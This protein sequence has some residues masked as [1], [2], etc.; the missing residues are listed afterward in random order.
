M[1]ISL[2]FTGGTIGS[3][4]S[5][6]GYI[7]ATPETT[8]QI[9]DKY[10][11]SNDIDVTFDCSE[12]YYILSENLHA[13]NLVMLANSIRQILN[14]GKNVD[15]IIITH[16]TD[17]LQYTAA[18]LSYL[19]GDISVPIVLVSSAYVLSD[20]RSNG[21]DNFAGAISF[22]SEH[23]GNGVFVSYKNTDN[24]LYIHRGNR[25]HYHPAHSADIYSLDNI[26]YA[27][28][29]ISAPIGSRILLNAD[30]KSSPNSISRLPISPDTLSLKEDTMQILRCRMHVGLSYASISEMLSVLPDIKCLFL[31]SYHSGTIKIDNNLRRLAKIASDKNILFL[32]SGL[33]ETEAEYDTVKEYSEL[34]II[35]ISK[36]TPIAQYCKLWLGLCNNLDIK[37]IMKNCYAEEHN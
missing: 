35:P 5:S 37:S 10:K 9:I 17:T 11:N 32:L 25:L 3:S 26:Y 24:V 13:Q 4:I 28:C 34:N 8:C 20:P 15:G 23:S 16:G 19:F 2:I 30:Y 21:Y 1:K 14:S 7:S 6:D 22:I 29:D 27:K 31:E 12:P 18:V 36:G 33:D